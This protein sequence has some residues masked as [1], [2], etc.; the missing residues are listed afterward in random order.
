MA[1]FAISNI[2]IKGISACVPPTVER[3]DEIPFYTADEAQAVVEATGVIQKHIASEGVTASDLCTAAAKKLLE[4]LNWEPS[5]VDFLCFV[6]QTPDYQNHPN[7]FV[8]H[9]KLGLSENCIVVD[10]FHGCPGWVMGLATSASMMSHGGFKR[11][12]LLV[13]DV[14][15]RTQY[16]LGKEDRPLFGD[17]GTATA[18]VFSEDASRIVFDMGTDSKN[19]EALIKKKGRLREPHTPESFNLEYDLLKGTKSTEGVDDLMDGM[20]VFAFGISKPPKSIKKLLEA[21]NN[22]IETIDKVVLHQANKMMVERILKKIK[23]PADKA[24]LGMINYGNTTS[25][26]I[27][28][29]IVTECS[30]EYSSKDL[31]TVCCG[32]GTGLSWASALFETNKICCPQLIIYNNE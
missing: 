1:Q 6:T 3:T 26:S 15:T 4:D 29:A 23:V 16:K 7:V 17:A 11:G 10:L 19:G 32:F 9:E 20:S 8:A 27:P 12:L 22:S 2:E 14:V 30:E 13:G 18:L 21:T 25:A 5:S 31:K 24:P 28:L